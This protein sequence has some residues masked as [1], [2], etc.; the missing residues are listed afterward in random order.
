MVLTTKD[1]HILDKDVTTMKARC[2]ENVAGALFTFVDPG[3]SWLWDLEPTCEVCILLHW[4]DP[5]ETY[6]SEQ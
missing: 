1:K 4:A 2:G 6:G 3:G 5:S